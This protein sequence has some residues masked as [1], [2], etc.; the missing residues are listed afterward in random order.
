MDS[1]LPLGITGIAEYADATVELKTGD[2]LMLMSDGVV[3]A[4]S[5]S[6]DLFGF[7]RTRKISGQ[8][9]ERMAQAAQAFGQEDDT[10]VLTLAFAQT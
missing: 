4:R 2:W 9:E 5:A 8:T 10:T 6:G 3:E 1:G 7:E